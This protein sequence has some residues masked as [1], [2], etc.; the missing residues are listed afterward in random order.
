MEGRDVASGGCLYPVADDSID[1]SVAVSD[2][3]KMIPAGKCFFCPAHIRDGATM[4]RISPDGHKPPIWA[5]GECATAAGHKA[6]PAVAEVL[7]A[8]KSKRLS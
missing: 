1:G 5:C 7:R 8:I 3:P 6:D 4:H 2:L